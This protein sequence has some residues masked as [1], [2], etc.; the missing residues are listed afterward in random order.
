MTKRTWS[1]LESVGMRPMDDA[2]REQ[3]RQ[4]ARDI[5][6]KSALWLLIL[7]PLIVADWLVFT[8]EKIHSVAVGLLGLLT[9]GAP[10][11]LFVAARNA[12]DRGKPLR[13]ALKGDEVEV[14]RGKL[15]ALLPVDP[16][17]VE[18]GKAGFFQG[19][20]DDSQEVELL[21][22]SSLVHRV[23]GRFASQFLKVDVLETA[24]PRD[25][26]RAGAKSGGSARRPR[27]RRMRR[28]VSR[29]RMLATWARRPPQLAH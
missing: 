5:A 20:P 27:W 18:L 14:F 1:G 23:D 26:V 9:L 3:L 16:A 25:I 19:D 4:R 12:Y 10:V 29:S 11:V 17:L 2:D 28:M 7:P 21:P 15:R 24:A 22:I 8:A 13:V 6:T